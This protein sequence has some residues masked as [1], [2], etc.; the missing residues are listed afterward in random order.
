MVSGV[1]GSNGA[2]RKVFV[3]HAWADKPA[4]KQ[5][6]DALRVRGVDAWY[7]EYEIGPATTSSR[8]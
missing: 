6:V 3:S 5:L 2:P 7:D 8:R 4:V 1:M